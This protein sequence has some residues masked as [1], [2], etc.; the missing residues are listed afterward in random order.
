M[1]RACPPEDSGGVPGYERLLEALRDPDHEEHD[2][3]RRWVGRR[4]NPETFDLAAVN[5]KLRRLK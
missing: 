4:F 3:V 1:A 5:R 2:D